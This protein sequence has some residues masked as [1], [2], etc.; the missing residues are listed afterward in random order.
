[1]TSP[2]VKYDAASNYQ[3]M[4]DEIRD[5]RTALEDVKAERNRLLVD[6]GALRAAL[7][8]VEQL[9]HHA[10][11]NLDPAYARQAASL[12]HLVRLDRSNLEDDE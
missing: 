5:L 3:R 6:N 9:A 12:A 7:G 8:D 4:A 11:T 10:A 1:M 2:G